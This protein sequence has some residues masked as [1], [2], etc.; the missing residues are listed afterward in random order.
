MKLEL[1]ERLKLWGMSLVHAETQANAVG[2]LFKRNSVYVSS[3]F[4]GAFAFG[5]GFDTAMTKWWEVRYSWRKRC[6][7][8]QDTDSCCFHRLTTAASSG[9]TSATRWVPLQPRSHWPGCTMAWPGDG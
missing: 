6:N 4:V 2:N 3:I 8:L 9:K 5:I 7:A 1:H